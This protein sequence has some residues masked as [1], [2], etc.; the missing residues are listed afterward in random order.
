MFFI[1]NI[2]NMK[3]SS[4]FYEFYV[5]RRVIKTDLEIEVMRYVVE[6]SSTAHR[7]VMRMA[8]PGKSEYQCESEFLHH[9]YSVGG[10]RH[11]SYTCICGSGTNGAILHYGHA[12]APNDRFIKAGELW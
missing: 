3:V 5:F 7:K 4:M 8:K 1:N 9:N 10:C 11:V 6:T 2:Q 12:G